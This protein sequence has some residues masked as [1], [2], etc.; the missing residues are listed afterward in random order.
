MNILSKVINSSISCLEPPW[1]V[2][3]N[4]LLCLMW[5][6]L[7]FLGFHS[8]FV[9]FELIGFESLCPPDELN[10]HATGLRQSENRRGHRASPCGN[11]LL[12]RIGFYLSNPDS[13]VPARTKFTYNLTHAVG[14]P[15]NPH[16]FPQSAI[17]HSVIRFPYVY[18]CLAKATL[19]P[20]TIQ[21]EHTVSQKIAH[22]PSATS[23]S[24]T[25]LFIH[26]L[27]ITQML[28]HGWRDILWTTYIKCSS[29]W[30]GVDFHLQKPLA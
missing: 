25:L 1:I 2:D 23:F 10:L 12:K 15:M 17:I 11:P 4:S 9:I 29:K 3:L 27:V 18:S 5:M 22:G 26:Q 13:A 24:T 28:I 16:D 21:T 7:H 20:V 8:T 6:T 19:I 14:E 30:L